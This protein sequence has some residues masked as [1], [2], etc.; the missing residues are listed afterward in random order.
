MDY[1]LLY[2]NNNINPSYNYCA[3]NNE[4]QH[5]EKKKKKKNGKKQTS[6][7]K[8]VKLSTDPQSVAARERRHRISERFKILQSLVPGGSKLDTVSMLE[9]AIV[10]IKFLQTQ[11]W[12][13]TH[14][15]PHQSLNINSNNTIDNNHMIVD[16]QPSAI[17]ND[18]PCDDCDQR[19]ISTQD[20]CGCFVQNANGYDHGMGQILEFQDSW[21]QIEGA[22]QAMHFDNV[23][24]LESL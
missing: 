23:V 10:Y 4:M 11:L 15:N 1:Y 13:L 5:L 9:E 24:P 7:S 21:F 12:W 20:D 17:F 2:G 8:E 6:G 16:E 3:N 22:Q 14:H 18:L 19:Q